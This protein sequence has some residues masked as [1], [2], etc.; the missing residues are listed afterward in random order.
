MLRRKCKK[1]LDEKSSRE[2]MDLTYLIPVIITLA[3]VLAWYI[4]EVRKRKG[5]KVKRVITEYSKEEGFAKEIMKIETPEERLQTMKRSRLAFVWGIAAFATIVLF[6]WFFLCIL[7]IF[8]S[9]RAV[10]IFPGPLPTFIQLPAWDIAFCAQVPVIELPSWSVFAAPLLIVPLIFVRYVTGPAGKMRRRKGGLKS[11]D[12]TIVL[13][14][15]GPY[16][17][18]RHPTYT[19]MIIGFPLVTLIICGLLR[20]LPLLA[21]VGIL[22]IIGE[23]V[24]WAIREEKHN[25]KKW[26]DEYRQYM[27]EVPRFNLIKGLRNQRKKKRQT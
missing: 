13:F 1:G 18:V 17:I 25:I 8:T 10:S 23:T 4:L 9:G 15:E 19:E 26:G 7:P 22:V 24:V 21:I 3:G 20:L 27:N 2:K 6:T 11:D 14:R 5:V 16:A 12:D